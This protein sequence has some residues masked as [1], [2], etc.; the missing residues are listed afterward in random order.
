MNPIR[1]NIPA[2][3]PIGLVVFL[4]LVCL[5]FLWKASISTNLGATDF[6]A[7]WSATYLLHKGLNPY[8]P[9]LIRGVEIAQTHIFTEA[10]LMAWNP[11][12]LYV[13]LLPLA[14]LSFP[15]AKS[16]WLI[17]NI[18]LVL[19]AILML[20]RIYLLPGNQKALIIFVLLALSLPQLISGI[21]IGQV[22]FLVFIGLVACILLIKKEQWFWAG[23]VLILTLIKP[24]IVLLPLIYLLLY[25]AKRRQWKG[26]LGLICA[27]IACLVVTTLF[28]P[29][30][31][32]DLI[33]E[34]AI[35]PVH[36]ATPTI[37]G[38]LVHFG[39]GDIVRY[40]II[41][42][43]PLPFIL[44]S[45][46]STLKMELAV[47]VLT[48]ITVPTTFY[49]WSFDQVILLI[50]ISQVFSWMARS[51]NKSINAWMAVGIGISLLITYIQRFQNANDV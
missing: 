9:A 48:L 13:F 2:W 44:L 42:L 26:W 45:H 14:W 38:L 1:K 33:G 4:T 31:V 19:A 20:A 46:Q 43:L 32:S 12:F 30:W 35:S 40:M 47:A 8:D 23:A 7:Y 41:L 29:E 39:A 34:L 18:V 5:V 16:I 3:L 6:R 28:R 51:R 25:M 37:G 21:V 49:G 50:P 15:I 11:P 27:G 10:T 17:I 24:H 36:M 22:V